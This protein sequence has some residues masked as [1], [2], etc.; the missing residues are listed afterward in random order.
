MEEE[1]LTTAEQEENVIPDETPVET[2]NADNDTETD[3][4]V[5]E[6][7]STESEESAESEEKPF[8]LHVKFNKQT[9]KLTADEATTYAQKGMKWDSFLPNYDKL[10]YLADAHG[11]SVS[12]LITSLV[13]SDEKSLY[14]SILEKCA[15]NEETAKRLHELEIEKRKATFK[16]ISEV[17]KQ[18]SEKESEELTKRLA[19]EYTELKKDIPDVADFS[20]LPK[21]VLNDAIEKGVS[22]YDAYLRYQFKQSKKAASVAAKQEKAKQQST[23]SVASK[24]TQ[25]TSPEIESLMKGLWGQ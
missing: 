21:S 23:G 22:L 4:T 20:K 1:I 12:D 18:E 19:D 15:G 3:T 17:E 7:E 9:R 2:D 13:E 8:M 5:T 24:E 25:N 10:K 11:K 16:S 14:E 6:S